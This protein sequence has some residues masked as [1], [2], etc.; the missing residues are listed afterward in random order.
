MPY[1]IDGHNLIGVLSEI[2]LDDPADEARL[3]QK[4]NGFA[5]RTQK[6][7]VVV[8]DH[9]LPGGKSRM[10]TRMVQVVFASGRSSADKVMMERIKKMPN[11]NGWII[12]SS[13]RDVMATARLHR[14]QTLSADE[15]AALMQTPPKPVIDKGEA[16][17]VKL[18]PT[19]IDEWLDL[20]GGEK[21]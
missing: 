9:G 20:F 7:C 19:E 12:V 11:R 14:M 3:V 8:F 18:S 4:L 13:D 10:S 5:A 1:L 6:N 17:D 21:S 2:G 15:F 16:E